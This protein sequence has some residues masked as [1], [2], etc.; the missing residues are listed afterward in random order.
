MKTG[1]IRTKMGLYCDEDYK[2]V[3]AVAEQ[4]GIPYSVN[5]EKEYWDRVFEYFLREYRLGR[6]PNPDVM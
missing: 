1:M 5:F 3:S 6:T 2:D 4:I